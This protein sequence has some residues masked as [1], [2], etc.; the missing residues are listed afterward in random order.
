MLPYLV[1]S[2]AEVCRTQVAMCPALA[3]NVPKLLGHGQVLLHV[4]Q[5][6]QEERR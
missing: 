2:L 5:G 6:L 4:V 1:V 3:G